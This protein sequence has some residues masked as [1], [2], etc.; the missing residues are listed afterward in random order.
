MKRIAIVD[1]FS[2]GKYIAQE[3]HNRGCELIHISSSPDLDEYYYQNFNSEIYSQSIIHKNMRET[4]NFIRDFNSEYVIPGTESGVSLAD[5][6]NHELQL[7]YRNH[8]EM[9]SSRRNK[10][11]MVEAVRSAGLNA[12][13]QI[14]V[15]NWQDALIWLRNGR[16]P[17]V[18]KPLESAGS[19]GV[20]ICHHEDE[21][22]A[23]FQQILNKKNK[24]NLINKEI[25]LQEF[26]EGIEYVVNLVFLKGAS[27]VT[28]VVKYHKRKLESGNIVYDID[29]IIDATDPAFQE[30]V[31][32]TQK[33]CASLGIENGPV[34]AEVMLT[35]N[36]PF[37]VE[38][39]A[40]S[41]GILRP[42][43]SDATTGLGQLAATV[44]SI[45]EPDSF[46]ALTKKPFYQLKKFSFNVCLISPQSGIF[47]SSKIISLAKSLPSFVKIELYVP[48]GHKV[49]ETKDVFSQPGTI[50]L[51]SADKSR[52]WADYQLIR[53]QERERIYFVQMDNTD[54]PLS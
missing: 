54:R 38:I 50:Y 28:E 20:F 4:L 6:I 13:K 53:E 51:A 44:L 36:G 47:E 32:Y 42:E 8:I 9:A 31:G 26:L 30:L 33:V 1:G 12:A 25:L 49:Y 23:A 14:K 52:L 43:V 19:D 10:Y 21:A 3:L 39:A 41:D 29:E 27:L 16:F 40:R 45:T 48:S 46:L 35:P 2:S 18:L 22:Y 37:L 5:I 17:I 24:L 15:S 34:H 7:P 11:D